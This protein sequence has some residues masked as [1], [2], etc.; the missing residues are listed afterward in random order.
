MK[1]LYYVAETAKKLVSMFSHDM[2]QFISKPYK[3]TEIIRLR[4]DKTL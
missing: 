1:G 4:P 3:I 2:A